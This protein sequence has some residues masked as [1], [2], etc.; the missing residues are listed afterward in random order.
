MLL[1]LHIMLYQQQRQHT[2]LDLVQ[3]KKIQLIKYLVFY[4][5]YK[6]SIFN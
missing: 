3:S 5:L 4:G 6:W 2:S 1:K